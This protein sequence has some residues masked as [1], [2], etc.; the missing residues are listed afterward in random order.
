MQFR[1]V[2]SGYWGESYR[3]VSDGKTL[4]IDTTQGDQPVVLRAAPKTIP[5]AD[6]QLAKGG[7]ESNPI[8]EML[9]GSGSLET[10]LAPDSPIKRVKGEGALDAI[11]FRSKAYG[12]VTVFYPSGSELP[13]PRVIEYFNSESILQYFVDEP[14]SVTS[15]FDGKTR[16]ELSFRNINRALPAS[17]FDTSPP[18]GAPVDDQRKSKGGGGF[19]R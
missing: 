18:A 13:L 9:E 14:E 3:A 16:L 12:W 1:I 17:T 6:R 7:S 15:Q 5:Q 19:D 4:L 2:A 10:L 8:F 11:E